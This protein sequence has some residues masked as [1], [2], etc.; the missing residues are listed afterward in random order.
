MKFDF[1]L[2][3]GGGAG[4]GGS[5]RGSS[6]PPSSHKPNSK[7]TQYKNGKK[8]QERWYDKFGKPK[9]DRDHTNHGNP[10][11]HP[12]VPHYHDWKDGH[13]GKWY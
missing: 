4:S 3:G 7:Y 2:F 6:R 5:Y 11:L 1:Q 9:R 10:K 8:I 12:K 13:R